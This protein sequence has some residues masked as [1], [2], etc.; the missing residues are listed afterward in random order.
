MAT[1]VT[2]EEPYVHPYVLGQRVEDLVKQMKQMQV[3]MED[4]AMMAVAYTLTTGLLL[5]LLPHLMLE[6][7]RMASLVDRDPHQCR[8]T[9][10]GCARP[11]EPY[12]EDHFDR[13]GDQWSR[14]ARG[15][16]ITYGHNW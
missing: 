15:V 11:A 12:H 2:P 8:A 5:D 10:L 9:Y 16:S 6:H 3:D 14:T 13:S 4:N 1:D 7:R